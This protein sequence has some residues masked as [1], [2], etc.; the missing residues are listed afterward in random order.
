MDLPLSGPAAR[1]SAHP[2]SHPRL[3]IR[4]RGTGAGAWSVF[5]DLADLEFLAHAC[6]RCGGEHR[7]IVRHG[8]RLVDLPCCDPR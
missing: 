6:G 1:H 4:A 2:G 7:I 8:Q 3:E 5:R